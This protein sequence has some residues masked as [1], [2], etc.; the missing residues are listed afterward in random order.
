[1][2]AFNSRSECTLFKDATVGVGDVVLRF[3]FNTIDNVQSFQAALLHYTVQHKVLQVQKV[4]FTEV[5]GHPKRPLSLSP[6]GLFM[7]VWEKARPDFLP[8]D[9]AAEPGPSN[10]RLD[11]FYLIPSNTT[12]SPK[13][14]IFLTRDCQMQFALP[15]PSQVTDKIFSDSAEPHGIACKLVK[16]FHHFP[17]ICIPSESRKPRQEVYEFL[18]RCSIPLIQGLLDPDASV[19]DIRKREVKKVK[20]MELVMETK[21]GYDT[22]RA[23]VDKAWAK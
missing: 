15:L 13:A 14:L 16:E 2:Y 12:Q 23:H 17:L 19:D 9:K 8:V 5:S 10:G 20:R 18:W 22:I 4:T 6:P 21:L 7:Q 11:D 3:E 1:M